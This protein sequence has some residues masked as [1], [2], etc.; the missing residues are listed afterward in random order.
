EQL[1]LA[2]RFQV[3][4]LTESMRRAA[5]SL[6]A[7]F[8]WQPEAPWPFLPSASYPWSR[9][10]RFGSK[11]LSPIAW[12]EHT[13]PTPP[14]AIVGPP[15]DCLRILRFRR[16]LGKDNLRNRSIRRQSFGGPTMAE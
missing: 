5:A 11:L 10:Q 13:S 16:F 14:S 1:G 12:A 8:Q 15:K 4:M 9:R 2:S 7:N 6:S 3:Q